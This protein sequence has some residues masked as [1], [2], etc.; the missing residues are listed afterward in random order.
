MTV[1]QWLS[2]WR[3]RVPEGFSVLVTSPMNRREPRFSTFSGIVDFD[4]GFFHVNSP[5]VWEAYPY[6][7]TVE[8]GTPIVHLVPFSR[9]GVVT[10]A[11]IRRMDE[12][13]AEEAKRELEQKRGNF[14]RY[15]EEKW[16]PKRGARVIERE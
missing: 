4:R 12:A 10:D 16:V 6:S 9:S 8:R 1:L 3:I 13:D 11:K 2:P 7:G 15:R 14:S 5:F